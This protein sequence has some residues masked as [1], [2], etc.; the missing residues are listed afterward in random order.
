MKKIC[1]IL[2]FLM[3]IVIF[4]APIIMPLINGYFAGRHALYLVFSL[5]FFIIIDAI[6]IDNYK[7]LGDSK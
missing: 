4:I 3:E 1:L 6:L 5:V 2:I 7:K